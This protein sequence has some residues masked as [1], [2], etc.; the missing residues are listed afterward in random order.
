MLCESS[1]DGSYSLSELR[2]RFNEA[3]ANDRRLRLTED[4]A[5]ILRGLIDSSELPMYRL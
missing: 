3:I 2:D 4:F 5:P 1:D